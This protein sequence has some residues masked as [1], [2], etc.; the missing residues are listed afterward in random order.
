MAQY[1]RNVLNVGFRNRDKSNKTFEIPDECPVCHSHIAPEFKLAYALAPNQPAQVVWR[2]TNDRCDQLF[3]TKYTWSAEHNNSLYQLVKS[4]PVK[5]TQ[6]SFSDE[7]VGTSPDFVSI[8]SEASAAEEYGLLHVCGPGYR[9]ALEYLLK[10]YLITLSPLDSVKIKAES[11]GTC[12]N[13]RV[14]NPKLKECAKRAAWLGNDETHYERRWM[15]QDL[16]DLKTLI[17]LSVRW[18]EIQLL[19]NGYMTTMP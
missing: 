8:Y 10:D 5:P 19:T 9:K 18:I 6:R 17:E 7:I 15:E 3:V 13:S 4:E 11:L 14:S 2:C 1:S 16:Q 12:I